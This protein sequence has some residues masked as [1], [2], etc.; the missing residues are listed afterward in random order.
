MMG[1]FIMSG[2]PQSDWLTVRAARLVFLALTLVR[3]ELF[4]E[5]CLDVYGLAQGCHGKFDFLAAS[6]AYADGQG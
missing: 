5:T 4:L 1:T 3:V 6:R 2:F